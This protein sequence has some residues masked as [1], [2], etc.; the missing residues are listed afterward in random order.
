MNLYLAPME[1]ITGHVF[2]NVYHHYYDGADKYFSPYISHRNFSARERSDILPE[3]NRGMVLIPQILTNHADE[4]IDIAH[5]LKEEYGYGEVNLN[6]GCP[7]PTVAPKNRGAGFLRVPDEL[8]L[9]L[10]DIFDKSDVKI[11]V[12]T[13]TGYENHEGFDRIIELFNEY[14]LT[15]LIVHPRCREDYY[16]RPVSKE[17]YA[18]AA[19]NSRHHLCYNGDVYTVEDAEAITLGFGS[20]DI[21]CGR[22][23]LT[24]PALFN[25]IRMS[26]AGEQ[27]FL[28][29]AKEAHTAGKLKT[30]AQARV[31]ETE[32]RADLSEKHL[33]A[34][35][36]ELCDAYQEDLSGDK[37]VLFKMKEL[38][39]YL[40]SRYEKGEK[41]LKKVRKCQ[42]V[43]DFKS[44][45]MESGAYGYRA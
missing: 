28:G 3:N 5:K 33:K 40:S 20:P 4:F 16:A 21:M 37:N 36:R 26:I 18:I 45:L 11:S 32:K 15:E 10:D 29:K 42:T 19:E 6:L 39:F 12:K 7:S 38:Y 13:R 23:I 1:G 9:F 25:R 22:G 35:V 2:R 43:A 34:F 24:D 31:L 27:A 41:L 8:R 30:G 17:A 14:P 44:V